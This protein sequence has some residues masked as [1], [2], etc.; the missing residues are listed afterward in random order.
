MLGVHD[1]QLTTVSRCLLFI[2]ALL[3]DLIYLSIYLSMFVYS[4]G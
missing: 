2:A 1:A 4:C 3:T